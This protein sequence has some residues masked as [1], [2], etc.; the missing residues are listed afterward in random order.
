MNENSTFT[1]IPQEIA[2]LDLS[3]VDEEYRP[4]IRYM[5]ARH[6][7][8]WSGELGEIKNTVHRI[9]GILEARP[10]DKCL[11]AKA[12]ATFQRALD[13]ALTRYKWRTCIVCIDDVVIFSKSVREHI[14]HVDELLTDLELAGIS[15]KFRKCEFFHDRIKY[16]GHIIRPGVLEIDASLTKSL[17]EAHPP[18]SVT[19]L[20][21]FL[22]AANVY[23]KFIRRYAT[24]ASPLFE[25]LKDLPEGAQ[26]KGSKHS[27]DLNDEQ[28]EAFKELVNR[29]CNPSI[30]AIPAPNRRFSIDTDASPAQIGVALFQED[31]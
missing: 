25:I 12:P 13:M 16:L 1:D 22:G 30:L 18:K 27:I 2:E 7:K 9:E 21:S 10:F 17:R 31:D 24:I 29:M 26:E 5:L 23:R 14:S 6:G 8:M 19:E 15:L 20:R 3:K 28:H 4:E 11:I